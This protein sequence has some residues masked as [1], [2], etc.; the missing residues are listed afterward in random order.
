MFPNANIWL[1]GEF[2]GVR[3][4]GRVSMVTLHAGHSL[5]GGLASLIGITF[6]APV[7]AFEAPAER[8][9]ARRLHLPSPVRSRNEFSCVRSDIACSPRSN[10]S[11]TSTTLQTPSRWVCVLGFLLAALSAVMPWNQG[12]SPHWSPSL[13]EED[14]SNASRARCHLGNVLKYDTVSKW[15]WSVDVRNHGITVIVDKLLSADWEEEDE[16]SGD[17]GADRKRNVPKMTDEGDCVVSRAMH[18]T[19]SVSSS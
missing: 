5:G 6:G 15:G 17:N 13:H 2:S 11:L 16:G 7:V 18:R 1:T 12:S 3:N 19:N 9:A 10:M 4:P 8:M 14:G